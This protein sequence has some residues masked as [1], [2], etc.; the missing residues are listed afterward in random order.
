MRGNLR[1]SG[2]HRC[3]GRLGLRGQLWLGGETLGADNRPDA[4]GGVGAAAS[5]ALRVKL[6]EG[7]QGTVHV[8]DVLFQPFQPL[9]CQAFAHTA[10]RR[11]SGRD[12]RTGSV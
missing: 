1:P 4:V 3:G 5:F 11:H 9:G 12:G 7:G 6:L 2:G 8:G 10:Q